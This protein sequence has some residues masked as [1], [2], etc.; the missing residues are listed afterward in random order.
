MHSNIVVL[1]PEPEE[2]LHSVLIT[3]WRLSGFF[4]FPFFTKSLFRHV[5]DGRGWSWDYKRICPYFDPCRMTGWALLHKTL[6]LPSITP[7]MPPEVANAGYRRIDGDRRIFGCDT[8]P[9][10]RPFLNDPL[11]YC[12]IC[13][14]TQLMRHHR[15]FWLRPHQLDHVEVCWRHKVKLISAIPNRGVSKFPHEY[16]DQ[17]IISSKNFSEIWLAQQAYE[18]LISNHSASDSKIRQ[19]VYLNQAIRIGYRNGKRIDYQSMANHLINTFGSVFLDR[20]MQ[21]SEARH[22]ATRIKITING[23]DSIIRPVNHLLCIQVL[24]GDQSQFF[25]RVRSA[26]PPN[27]EKTLK[28]INQEKSEKS[29]IHRDIFI[30]ELKSKGLEVMTELDKRFPLTHAWILKHA[31]VW[32]RRKI[33]EHI[34]GPNRIQILRQRA[35]DLRMKSKREKEYLRCKSTDIDNIQQSDAGSSLYL[36]NHKSAREKFDSL[37][38]TLCKIQTNEPLSLQ[39]DY[40]DKSIN[41][42]KIY[43]DQNEQPWG[44]VG[45]T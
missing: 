10:W 17:T 8:E 12:P 1:E 41:H 37:T 20:V 30:K 26:A 11:K 25:Q 23:E 45:D 2:T 21:T 7:F 13:T 6:L 33:A 29:N 38:A 19:H 4:T 9:V 34:Q 15:S 5:S 31:L 36:N 28:A 22:I 18:L 16:V 32:S 3:G 14:Q 40:S 24:F 27:L 39:S 35:S 44:M 43:D 42:Q